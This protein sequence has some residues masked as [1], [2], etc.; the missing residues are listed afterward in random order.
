M[1][2]VTMMRSTASRRKSSESLL[3]KARSTRTT[4]SFTLQI[5]SDAVLNEQ[6]FLQLSKMYLTKVVTSQ[7]DV[8]ILCHVS[9]QIKTSS[10][11]F[12]QM[13]KEFK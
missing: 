6:P 5:T 9:L 2:D 3:K 8:K 1:Y 10:K 7:G 13:T 4:C 12:S 11:T